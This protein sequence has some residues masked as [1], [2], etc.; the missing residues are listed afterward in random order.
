MSV[1]SIFEKAGVNAL[2]IISLISL[3]V[4]LII[5]FEAAAPFKMFGAEIFIANMLGII[6]TR[7]MAGLVTAIIL[8]GRSGQIPDAVL[9]GDDRV[10][11]DASAGQLV[12]RPA[13]ANK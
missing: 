11:L 12:V 8:A 9:V 2:P 1:S 13:P 7:E 5:A 10:Y 4:G 6:M 3:L